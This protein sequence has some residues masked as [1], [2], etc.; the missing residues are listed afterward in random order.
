MLPHIINILQ[1]FIPVCIS[2]L[3]V[4]E[5][6]KHKTD[7]VYVYKVNEASDSSV[8]VCTIPDNLCK[9]KQYHLIL[10]KKNIEYKIYIWFL[11][12]SKYG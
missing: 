11:K 8:F 2:I 10:G 9:Q 4:N 3:T 5:L 1:L 12:C 6:S 7:S